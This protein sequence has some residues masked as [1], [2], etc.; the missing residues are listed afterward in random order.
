LIQCRGYRNR[1][2]NVKDFVGATYWVLVGALVVPATY[3]TLLYPGPAYL[4]MIPIAMGIVGV[5][6]A[7]LRNVWALLIGFG[8]LPALV[9]TWNLLTDALRINWSCSGISFGNVQTGYG[10]AGPDGEQVI[11][12][13]I[14]AQFIVM[15][16]VFWGIT[17]SGLV[18]WIAARRLTDASSGG[19]DHGRR[20]GTV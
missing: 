7:G 13:T 20:T 5:L 9:L 17:F 11:C 3:F 16:A 8:G 4:L 6:L 1:T 15:A 10:Y 19:G 14:P 18:V 12:E 2:P